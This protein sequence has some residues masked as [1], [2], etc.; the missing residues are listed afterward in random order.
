MI[1]ITTISEINH[2]IDGLLLN[3]NTCRVLQLIVIKP[4]G[5]P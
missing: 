5:V 2:F 3:K 1:G 4:T